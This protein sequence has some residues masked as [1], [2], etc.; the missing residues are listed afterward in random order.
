ML[1]TVITWNFLAIL[2]IY[3]SLLRLRVT[4]LPAVAQ[5]RQL[6]RQLAVGTQGA[7]LRIS[8]HFV[9]EWTN[10]GKVFP[11]L[12]GEEQKWATGLGQAPRCA[13]RGS[14][15]LVSCPMGMCKELCEDSSA[16]FG[17]SWPVFGL[18]WVCSS[19]GR[20]TFPGRV[21]PFTLGTIWWGQKNK[22]L[23]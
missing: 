6:W 5:P 19:L 17:E 11:K 14:C 18:T 12:K 23:A 1:H 20:G 8:A 2:G 22:I 3:S 13:R 4:S 7:S 21:R 9:G 15:H 16:S 10:A